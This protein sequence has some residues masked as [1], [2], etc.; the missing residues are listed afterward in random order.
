MAAD[1]RV[2]RQ[3]KQT[4]MGSLSPVQ[5][6]GALSSILST[7]ASVARQPP[8]FAAMSVDWSIVIKQ[9]LLIYK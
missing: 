8:Q 2:Q 9:V 6:I 4:G 5:G 1:P 3:A 7:L